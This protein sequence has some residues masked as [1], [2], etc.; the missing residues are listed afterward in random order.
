MSKLLSASLSL[1]HV[2][3]LQLTARWLPWLQHVTAG[4]CNPHCHLPPRCAA[5]H[6]VNSLHAPQTS[7]MDCSDS[8]YQKMTQ[9]K[10]NR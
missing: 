1:M 7:K 3:F 5:L 10:V 9:G 4:F 8:V 2:S 6:R